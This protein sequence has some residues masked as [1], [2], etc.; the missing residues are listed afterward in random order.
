MFLIT[1][2]YL[3]ELN[4]VCQHEIRGEGFLLYTDILDRPTKVKRL[5]TDGLVLDR[6]LENGNISRRGSVIP[7]SRFVRIYWEDNSL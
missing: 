6:T 7:P 5:M 4:S 2:L 1:V 3:D